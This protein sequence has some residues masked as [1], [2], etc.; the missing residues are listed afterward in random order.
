MSIE[1]FDEEWKQILWHER[2]LK[3][4]RRAEMMG[5]IDT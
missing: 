1:S 4:A 2:R 3:Q 5:S